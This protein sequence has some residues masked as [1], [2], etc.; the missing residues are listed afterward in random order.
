MGGSHYCMVNDVSGGGFMPHETMSPKSKAVSLQRPA[1]SL[2]L[3]I[4]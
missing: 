1:V 3:A 4:T 2:K